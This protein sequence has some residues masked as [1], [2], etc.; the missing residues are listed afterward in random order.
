MRKII[1]GVALLTSVILLSGCTVVENFAKEPLPSPDVTAS[2]AVQEI[3]DSEYAELLGYADGVSEL[4]GVDVTGLIE[5]TGK[6]PSEF[7]GDTSYFKAYFNKEDLPE[8][9]FVAWSSEQPWSDMWI[10]YIPTEVDDI[11]GFEG[12]IGKEN[13]EEQWF[14]VYNDNDTNDTKE[15]DLVELAFFLS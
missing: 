15:K 4:W 13:T 1:S 12:A 5:S 8:E 6:K 3:S 10:D 14:V 2:P 9:D 7:S 11:W